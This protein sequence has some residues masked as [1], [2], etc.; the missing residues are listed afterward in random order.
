MNQKSNEIV[1]TGMGVVTPIGCGLIDFWDS[2]KTGAQGFSE[3]PYFDASQYRNTSAGVV[4]EAGRSEELGRSC[5]YA[6]MALS[7][8]LEDSS[9]VERRGLGIV[10]ASNFGGFLPVL[11][12]LTEEFGITGPAL[13]LSRQ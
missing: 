5:A 8:A 9:L 7:Q 11:Q 3:I 2:L 4:G 1:V 10:A 6:F 13:S 12:K